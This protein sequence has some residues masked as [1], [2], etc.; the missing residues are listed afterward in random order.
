MESMYERFTDRARKIVQLANQEAERLG[1]EHIGPE[2][3]LLGL[4]KEG[5][6]V[7]CLA[8]KTSG[9]EPDGL[10]REV[11]KLIQPGL[12]RYSRGKL[13]FTPE[14]T[15]AL[16]DARAE[17][18]RLNNFRFVASEH[19]LLGMMLGNN[20]LV[21]Q[22]INRCGLTLEQARLEVVRTAATARFQGNPP[23]ACPNCGHSVVRVLW[24]H[25]IDHRDMDELTSGKAIRAPWRE[26]A[27]PAWACL[28]C[29]PAWSEV[30]SLAWQEHELQMAK[31][32][33]AVAGDYATIRQHNEVQADVRRRLDGLLE[34]LLPAQTTNEP[35]YRD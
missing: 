4:L 19:L 17:A 15:K 28:Q 18:Y 16:E 5:S 25:V 1:H 8:I 20:S 23:E 29:V 3:L 7:A 14:A 9:I 12:V 26:S 10:R 33:A 35:H 2:H 34:E 32:R 6:G 27:G 13:P 21:V 30:H 24:S 22:A 11:E 31:Q